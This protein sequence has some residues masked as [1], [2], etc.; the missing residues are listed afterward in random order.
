M[1][2]A[3]LGRAGSLTKAPFIKPRT[4]RRRRER[5]GVKVFKRGK[6]EWCWALK[7]EVEGQHDED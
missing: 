2:R 4:L 7:D 3:D 5:M 6:R 1:K